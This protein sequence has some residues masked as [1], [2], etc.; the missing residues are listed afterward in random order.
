MCVYFYLGLRTR[1]VRLKTVTLSAYLPPPRALLH[2]PRLS[3]GSQQAHP[4][5]VS[6]AWLE[7]DVSGSLNTEHLIS[8][9]LNPIQWQQK[10]LYIHT[11]A[12]HY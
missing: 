11:K 3:K 8:G 4:L 5:Q 7:R 12:S 1:S 9:S 10:I 2:L 6:V